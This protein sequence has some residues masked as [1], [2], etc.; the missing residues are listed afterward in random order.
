MHL[1][2]TVSVIARVTGFT[3]GG[4][5][6]TATRYTRGSHFENGFTPRE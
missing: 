1:F 2:R 5:K 4:G 6:I 3:N